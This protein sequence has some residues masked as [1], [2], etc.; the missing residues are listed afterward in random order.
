MKIVAVDVGSNSIRALGLEI[1]DSKITEL[2]RL[3]AVPRLAQGINK[4]KIIEASAVEEAQAA[5]KEFVFKIESMAFDYMVACGTAVFRRALNGDE[6]ARKLSK[7]LGT[8]IAIIDSFTEA[9]LTYQGAISDFDS[10][11]HVIDVGGGS[12]EFIGGYQKKYFYSI[13]WGA[14]NLS[15]EVAL[16]YQELADFFKQQ[17]PSSLKK[18]QVQQLVFTGGTAA[19]L[20]AMS[21][22]LLK[23]D[24]QKIH[25]TYL[26]CNWLSK[27]IEELMNMNQQQLLKVKGLEKSR[28]DIIIAGAIIL[29]EILAFTQ[30]EGAYVSSKDLLEGLIYQKLNWRK[31]T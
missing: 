3:R 30:Q 24:P 6:V 1:A 28:T 17:I 27:T 20:A 19:T 2:L 25:Q 7:T 31:S 22:S 21:K 29:R 5:L 4:Q 10:L 8:E 23:F 16:T 18:E 12:T 15:E 9:Q 26:T 11:T 13:P 14:V